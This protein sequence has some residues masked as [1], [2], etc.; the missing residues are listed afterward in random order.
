MK[1][2]VTFCDSTIAVALKRAIPTPDIM[3]I[4]R[5]LSKYPVEFFDVPLSAVNDEFKTATKKYSLP[6]RCSI[7]ADETD[8][9]TKAD[10]FSNLCIHFSKRVPT[11]SEVEKVLRPMRDKQIWICLDHAGEISDDTLLGIAKAA[12]PFHVSGII[13]ADTAGDFFKLSERLKGLSAKNAGVN[14]YSAD[15]SLGLAAANSLGAIRAGIGRIGVSCAG[16]G[17]Y[18]PFEEILMAEKHLWHFQIKEGRSLAPDFSRVFRLMHETLPETK[19][20]LGKRVF[21]H[22]SGIHVDGILKKPQLYEIIQPSDVGLTRKLVI[23]KHSGTASLLHKLK[24]YSLSLRKEDAARLLV[25][26]RDKAQMQKHSLTDEQV[27][28]LYKQLF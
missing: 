5:I 14:E 4:A 9:F 18:A 7:E 13:Y 23:G 16:I 19:A 22:E 1:N 3:E 28:K 26:V 11:P 6:V 12:E 21:A 17:G 25:L 10:G 8:I 24:E 2:P 20:L 27:L 15:N